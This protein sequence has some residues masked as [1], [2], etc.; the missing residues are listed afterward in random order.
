MNFKIVETVLI[1][2]GGQSVRINKS[3]YDPKV[4]E[5]WVEPSRPV[6]LKTKG[7]KKVNSGKK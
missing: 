5:L 6:V 7:Q 3:D 4:D 2:R 1:D